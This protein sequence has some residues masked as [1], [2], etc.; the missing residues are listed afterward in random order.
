LKKLIEG[1]ETIKINVDPEAEIEGISFN[2]KEVKRGD[3]FVAVKGLHTDGHNY[4]GD[5][6]ARGAVA[7]ISERD[8]QGPIV[9]VKDSRDALAYISNNFYG[10][11]SEKMTL[12]GVTG[13]NGKTTTAF[14]IKEIIESSGRRTG[15]IGTISYRIGDEEFP[16]IHTTPEAPEYQALL[17]RMLR[18]GCL[19]AV[20]EVSSHALAQKR[21]DY[22]R[23]TTAVFTNLTR[24]HL[25]FHITMENYFESK[26]R[27]FYELLKEGGTAIINLDDPYGRAL[28]DGL[29]N[30]H[31]ITYA[32][33][34]DSDAT[35]YD[36]INKP[37]GLRF[38]VRYRGV[39]YPIESP[40]VGIPNVYNILAS[41]CA[42]ISLGID[43]ESIFGALKRVEKIR[44]RFERVSL[45]QDFLCVIDYAHTEDALRRLILTARDFTEGRIITVFG[46]GGDRDRGKRPLMGR[47]AT[48]LSDMVFITSDNPRT[49]DP[50]AIIKEIEEGCTKKNY[51]VVVDRK[52]AIYEA[53]AF[54]KKA[55]TVLIAGKG[56]EDYQEIDGIRHHFSDREIAIEAIRAKLGGKD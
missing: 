45:G 33:D 13:T 3:I 25:D 43:R 46:C 52:E 15:L 54:A 42:A 36:I 24:D 31:S 16:S 20:S 14:L 27:L 23:F 7:V 35:A 21:A 30:R 26:K 28:R 53:V 37:N 2:S 6:V 9:V 22:T 12:I 40:L 4:I 44:G 38:K 11:P 39:I 34:S 8:F 5:A 18:A 48:E 56:H 47:T 19:Y 41:V 29:K 10:R 55:D 51:K 17:A 32:I 50:E 1:M 49:E